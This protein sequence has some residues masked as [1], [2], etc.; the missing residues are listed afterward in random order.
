M[1]VKILIADDE[2]D[3][4]LLIRQRFRKQIRDNVYDFVFARDGAEALERLQHD[5]DIQLVLSD[6][7]MPVMDGLTLLARIKDL[8]PLVLPVIVSAYGDLT[9]IR[10]AMNRGAFDFLTKPI[11]F[12]DFEA[13]ISKTMQQALALQQAAQTRDQ[14]SAIQRELD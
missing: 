13:T 14:L 7:N 2:P 5:G 12:Q 9:N 4:E 3:L 10:A 8:N 6:I 11:D 1:A